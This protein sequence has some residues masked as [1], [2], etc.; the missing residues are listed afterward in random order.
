MEKMIISDPE[1]RLDAAQLV[2]DQGYAVKAA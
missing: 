2:V 1:F